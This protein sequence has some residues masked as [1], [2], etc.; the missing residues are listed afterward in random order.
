MDRTFLLVFN[1]LR[2]D[3]A[4]HGSWASNRRLARPQFHPTSGDPY[5]AQ[6]A[7]LAS[8]GRGCGVKNPRDSVGITTPRRLRLLPDHHPLNPG[9]RK[10]SMNTTMQRRQFLTSA[11]VGMTAPFILDSFVHAQERKGQGP[12]NRINLGFIGVGMMG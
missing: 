8:P 4:T 12:N 7:E 1:G 9:R 2:P 10:L 6:S 5:I 11:A 3:R